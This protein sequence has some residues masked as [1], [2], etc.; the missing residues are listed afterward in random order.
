[1]WILGWNKNNVRFLRY[2]LSKKYHVSYWK[3]FI[4]KLQI[5]LIHIVKFPK[6]NSIP[7]AS[8]KRRGKRVI[9]LMAILKVLG[10]FAFLFVYHCL[11]FC[12]MLTYNTFLIYR[13]H[14][15]WVGPC[16]QPDGICIRRYAKYYSLGGVWYV[17]IAPVMK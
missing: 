5:V 12:L 14:F 3:P 9:I 11:L 10:T 4:W 1:M 16:I 2:D 17:V 15:T 6:I 13:I 8:G 7:Y